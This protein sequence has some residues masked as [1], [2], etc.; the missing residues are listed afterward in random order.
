MERLRLRP[1]QTAAIV[2]H[3]RAVYPDEGCGLLAVP[4]DDDGVIRLY[5]IRNI[6]EQPRTR[7]LGEP[8]EIVE[9][10]LEIEG[11]G[12]RLGAIY[13]SHPRGPAWPSE[14]DVRQAYYPSAL[15]LLVS[16]ARLD[17]PELR[18]F[19]IRDGTIRECPLT[20]EVDGEEERRG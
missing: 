14:E 4:G 8:L 7:F 13:H 11:A 9:A 15:T 18:L 12:W 20:I 19:A 5:P 3:L 1:A 17:K 10:L 16:L 6:A 2:A